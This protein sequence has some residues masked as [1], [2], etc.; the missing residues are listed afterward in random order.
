M[1]DDPNKS[2]GDLYGI[3]RQRDQVQGLSEAVTAPY[4]G[5][6]VED[7][8]KVSMEE[9]QKYQKNYG[10]NQDQANILSGATS[11]K[12]LDYRADLLRK[13][14][15][16]KKTLEDAGWKGVLAEG[17]AYM[18]DPVTLPLM[19]VRAPVLAP[20]VIGMVGAKIAG[21][22]VLGGAVGLAT[23]AALATM[24]SNRD[25]RDV[26]IAGMGG[27]VGGAALESAVQMFGKVAGRVGAKAATDLGAD[28]GSSVPI[29]RTEPTLN[30]GERAPNTVE[31]TT[32][33]EHTP[34]ALIKEGDTKFDQAVTDHTE[35]ALYRATD[36]NLANEIPDPVQRKVALSEGDILETFKKELQPDAESKL[37][38][39]SR[40]VIEQDLHDANF[41]LQNAQESLAAL[42]DTPLTGSGKQLSAARSAR[43]DEIANLNNQV[44]ALTEQVQQHTDD[45]AKSN[46]GG[47]YHEAAADIDRLNQGI[48]PERFKE[49]YIEMKSQQGDD[50]PRFE[51]LKEQAGIKEDVPEKL[52]DTTEPLSESPFGGDSA[53]AARLNTTVLQEGELWEY[54][55]GFNAMRARLASLGQRTPVYKQ[56]GSTSATVRML[57]NIK[58]A[59]LR[60]ATNIFFENPLGSRTGVQSVHTL[61]DFFEKKLAPEL[62]FGNNQALRDYFGEVGITKRDMLYRPAKINEATL[63]FDKQVVLKINS[64]EG[65]D[66]RIYPDDDAITRAAKLRAKAFKQGL[67]LNQRYGV[68][69]W[70]GIQSDVNYHPVVDDL[71]KFTDALDKFDEADVVDTM[72]NAYMNGKVKLTRKS[73]ELVA[74]AKM[75]RYYT[76]NLGKVSSAE[77][78]SNAGVLKNVLK[79]LYSSP[80]DL[81]NRIKANFDFLP[82]G[83]VN[84][85]SNLAMT[86]PERSELLNALRKELVG[87]EGEKLG[88]V[89]SGEVAQKMA[90]SIYKEQYSADASN[91]VKE[92]YSKNLSPEQIDDIVQEVITKE[93]NANVSSR[94]M[95]SL[96]PD[97][98][99]SSTFD[100]GGTKLQY[101]DLMDTSVERSVKYLNE[102]SANA[103][104]AA[105][106]IRSRF[107][108]EKLIDDLFTKHREDLHELARKGEDFSAYRKQ[109]DG[110][111][112]DFATAMKHLYREPLEEQTGSQVAGKL[113]GRI[114][115][116]ALMGFSGTAQMADLGI[117]LARSGIIAVAKNVPMVSYNGVKSGLG[118]TETFVRDMQLNNIKNVM[119]AVSQQE[120]LFGHKLYK[121]SEYSDAVIGKF[122]KMDRALAN[123]GWVQGLMNL[124]RP[125]QGA[126]DELSARSLMDNVMQMA[127]GD[128]FTGKSRKQFIEIGKIDE[129]SLDAALSH[130]MEND[131]KGINMYDAMRS[132]RPELRDK[133]G[134]A[135]RTI[136][137]SN[138]GRSYFGELPMFVNQEWGKYMLRLQTFMLNSWEKQVQRGIRYDKAGLTSSTLFGLGIAYATVGGEMQLRSLALPEDKRDEYISNKI[139]D[140]RM[141]TAVSR[142]SQFGLITLPIQMF[143]ST[144]LVPEDNELY[145]LGEYRGVAAGGATSKIAQGVKSGINLATDNSTDED[146]DAAN[147]RSI[148]PWMNT[149][150][151]AAFYNTYNEATK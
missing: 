33:P 13:Q 137:T 50:L 77:A 146:R 119:G 34:D 94:A 53:G 109:L 92:L 54:G 121:G 29:G 59:S 37:S 36:T 16:N 75:G 47:V 19:A 86:N 5:S 83:A 116:L 11:P 122:A 133:L 21:Q 140:H 71:N 99:A 88:D 103:A 98:T 22:A 41:K 124:M 38:R 7:G 43:S 70:S 24:D 107:E 135:I 27:A 117:T 60:G 134:T 139:D 91:L 79:S 18:S 42:S 110:Y 97:I 25:T 106:G 62:V 23:E 4:L 72:V 46:R 14:N 12:D 136:H 1:A 96:K 10:L 8:Y 120:F 141:M 58:D 108:A 82:E 44:K 113:V 147:L 81:A 100:V 80:E 74:K 112:K 95:Q 148:I 126:I 128:M 61:S 26:L 15:E 129:S 68:R 31:A 142:V 65:G 73:A 17:A 56:T 67:R 105:N 63:E 118:M 40:Q 143:N 35:S 85:I 123:I 138:I 104:L 32:P 102:A 101:V 49:R 114:V 30:I 131:K 151:G 149:A 51:Q 20:R 52:N 69:G 28:A 150:Y 39:G 145:Q 111:Q 2:F 9:A 3:A 84:R 93:M 78:K 144:G 130:L 125:V 45:L 76:G 132:M 64:L 90:A 127:R 89:P 48:I 57:R 55:S 6:D 66:V 87:F 115:N